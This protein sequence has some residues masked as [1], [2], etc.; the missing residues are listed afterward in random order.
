MTTNGAA[1][2]AAAAVAHCVSDIEV[3]DFVALD[4]EFSGLFLSTE[5]GDRQAMTLE[6]YFKK[7][8][9]SIPHF[10]P[11]QLGICCVRHRPKGGAGDGGPWEL[12]AHEFNLWPSD[13][14]LFTSDLQSL[15]FLR[16]HGFDFN[17]FFERA[18]AYA[19]LPEAASDAAGAAAAAAAIRRL[20]PSHASRILEA[21]RTA[22]VPLVV[23]NGLLDLLHLWDKFFGEL[24][25]KMEEFN[26]SWVSHFPM[27]FDTR[28]IAS[29]GRFQVLKHAGGLSLEE[30]HRHLLG[31]SRSDAPQVT[32][33][34]AG[35]LLEGG[36]NGNGAGGTAHGSSAFDATL[37]A[38]VFL[39]EMDLW[40]RSADGSGGGSSGSA[41]SRKRRKVA[42]AGSAADAAAAPGAETDGGDAGGWTVVGGG[43]GGGKRH[44]EDGSGKARGAGGLTSPAQLETHRACKR[45]HNRLAVVG[46]SPGFIDLGPPP[47]PSFPT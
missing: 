5:R 27:L 30:L 6:A 1:A 41:G 2:A 21:L 32:L 10:L 37:T 18:H 3:A 13:R 44:L 17:T 22:N 9:E 47:G 11:L 36:P 19:R 12:R 45:F 28:L 31:L 25:E 15:R 26:R 20:A 43:G 33:E 4:L 14:R 7:C 38:E 40:I 8:V 24:P 23:H 35:P 29:E 39:M 34:R 42:E 46:A 16:A